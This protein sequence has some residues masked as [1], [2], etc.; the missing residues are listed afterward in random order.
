MGP[1]LVVR[2]RSSNASDFSAS[3]E[4]RSEQLVT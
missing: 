3:I 4:E 1:A 2:H